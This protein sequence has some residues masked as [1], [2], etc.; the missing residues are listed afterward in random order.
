VLDWRDEVAND[1][2]VPMVDIKKIRLEDGF[3]SEEKENPPSCANGDIRNF[4][5]I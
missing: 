4:F 3:S 1:I 5:L 2:A